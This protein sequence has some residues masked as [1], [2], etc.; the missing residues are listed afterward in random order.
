MTRYFYYRDRKMVFSNKGTTAKDL[1]ERMMNR[2]HGICFGNEEYIDEDGI[3]LTKGIRVYLIDDNSIDKELDVE[4]DGKVIVIK[5][6]LELSGGKCWWS[7]VDNNE[8]IK[9]EIEGIL[10]G[11]I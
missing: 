1:L 3:C 5:R 2:L 8:Q 7:V 9:R 4:N 11:V 6:N 10:D